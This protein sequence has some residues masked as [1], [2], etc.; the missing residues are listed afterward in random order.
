MKWTQTLRAAGLAGILA[1]PSALGWAASEPVAIA[2][3]E[4]QS[5]GGED[6]FCP[7]EP[8]RQQLVSQLSDRSEYVVQLAGPDRTPDFAITGTI[9]CS[10]GQR[11][12][13]EGIL[14]LQERFTITIATVKLKLQVTDPSTGATIGTATGQG[15]AQAEVKTSNLSEMP[16]E[17]QAT[18][19]ADSLLSQATAQA[20]KEALPQVETALRQRTQ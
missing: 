2:I 14:L 4:I 20:L 16:V 1:L 10:L 18:A 13:Q 11:Q 12:R 7:G 6:G 3:A 15:Q 8:I 17:G 5:V 19:N 9:D